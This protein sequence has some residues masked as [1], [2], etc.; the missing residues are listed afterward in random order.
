MHIYTFDFHLLVEK[1]IMSPQNNKY[2]RLVIIMDIGYNSTL[3]L[4]L[5]I[6]YSKIVPKRGAK[7]KTRYMYVVS[8]TENPNESLRIGLR[9][10][11]VKT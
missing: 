5:L 1:I 2:L 9:S 6:T 7:K 4:M 11:S 10:I 8:F 3:G